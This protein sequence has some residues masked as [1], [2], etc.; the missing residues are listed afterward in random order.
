VDGDVRHAQ[1]KRL[2]I[3]I[4]GHELDP[5]NPGLDHTV[6]GVDATATNTDNPNHRLVRLAT[7][8]RLVLRLLP[9][10]SR[11]FNYRLDLAARRA[12]LLGENPFKPLGRRLGAMP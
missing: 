3:G 7:P 6:D 9:P 11:S 2:K 12:R 10:V 8:R 5:G 1:L 4:D